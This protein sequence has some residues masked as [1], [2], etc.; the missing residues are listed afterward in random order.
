MIHIDRLCWYV[1]ELIDRQYNGL[2]LPQDESYVCTCKMVQQI[3][4]KNGKQLKLL[5]VLNP[6][7]WILVK[8]TNKGRKAFGNLIYSR[9]N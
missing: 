6:F 3:A 1:K 8:C 9:E 4:E 5:K 7:V 2:V